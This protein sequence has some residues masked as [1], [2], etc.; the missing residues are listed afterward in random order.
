M[1]LTAAQQLG[2]PWP[3]MER[4][5]DLLA[6]LLPDIGARLAALRP[7]LVAPLVRDLNALPGAAPCPTRP[8]SLALHDC[9]VGTIQEEGTARSHTHTTHL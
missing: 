7:A 3:E 4:R 9:A 5:L 2:M 1:G 6:A 8:R